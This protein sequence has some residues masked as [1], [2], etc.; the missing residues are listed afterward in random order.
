MRRETRGRPSKFSGREPKRF[1]LRVHPALF[2]QLKR[3]AGKRSLN[4]L[5][6]EVLQR[7]VEGAM[8]TASK[9]VKAGASS[10][11]LPTK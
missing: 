7:H 10:R 4:D 6:V 1:L 11:K 8:P 3:L 2:G 9:P 5:L